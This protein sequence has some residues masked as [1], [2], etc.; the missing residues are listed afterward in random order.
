[1]ALPV[2]VGINSSKPLST[3]LNS[4]QPPGSNTLKIIKWLE[5]V[6]ALVEG[7]A[8]SGS[9]FADEAGIGGITA[10][11]GHAAIQA[12]EGGFAGG[13][14]RWGDAVC[15]E[16]LAAFLAEPVGAPGLG[17]N[18]KDILLEFDFSDE[19]IQALVKQGAVHQS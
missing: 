7:F 18:S 11:A 16:F 15:F 5:A 17:E 2:N 4:S 10:G 6:I 13:L 14:F 9:E 8:G 12:E 19:E 3:P 1:M